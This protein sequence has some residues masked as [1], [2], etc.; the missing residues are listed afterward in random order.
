MS[1]ARFS[2]LLIGHRQNILIVDD[3]KSIRR[4]LSVLLKH[5]GLQVFEAGDGAEALEILRIHSIPTIICDWEMPVMDGIEF[6]QKVRQEF[7]DQHKYIIM[8]T[9]TAEK[10]AIEVIFNAGADDY[11]AKPIDPVALP[12]RLRGGLRIV[13]W[14]DDLRWF[15]EEISEK[16]RMLDEAYAKIREDLV[17]AEALQ[18]RYIP[19]YYRSISGVEFNGAF[20]PAFHTAGDIFNYVPLSETEVAAFSVDVSGHGVASALLA[21][22]IADSL[23]KGGA[24]TDLLYKKSRGVTRTRDPADVVTELNKAYVDGETDH[25]FTIIYCVLDLET[26]RLRYCQAGHPSMIV[27][28]EEGDA[29]EVGHGGLPVGMFADVNYETVECQLEPGD[30]VYIFSDGLVETEDKTGT[31]FGDDAMQAYLSEFANNTLQESI[32]KLVSAA[33][34]WQSSRSFEDDVSVLGFGVPKSA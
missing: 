27:V 30:R 31:H 7:A 18:R 16:K 26:L 11:M 17:V 29:R 32:A 23:S 10:N 20:I 15:N 2:D 1:D 6:C 14:H 25:Y 5:L 22:S 8:L 12:A 21:V 33:R 9:A 28:G 19:S 3:S 13:K 24:A 34:D 4:H